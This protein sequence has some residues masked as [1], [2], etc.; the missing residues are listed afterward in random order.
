MIV[1]TTVVELWPQY[2]K[3]IKIS[4][5]EVV[6]DEIEKSRDKSITKIYAEH[7]KGTCL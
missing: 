2:L 5:P 1:E 4:Y 7:G 3:G 6:V